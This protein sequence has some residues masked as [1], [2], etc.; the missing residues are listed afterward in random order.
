[1]KMSTP[2]QYFSLSN[3]SYL[4]KCVFEQLYFYDRKFKC[5]RCYLKMLIEI[6]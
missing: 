6:E 5:I 2:G 1:M 4:A 3:A